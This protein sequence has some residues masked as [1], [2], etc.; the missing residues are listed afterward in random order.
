[1]RRLIVALTASTTAKALARGSIPAN[2]RMAGSYDSLDRCCFRLLH[3]TC[4]GILEKQELFASK[5][6]SSTELFVSSPD[7]G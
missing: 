1:M 3:L 5:D 6:Y 7:K 2:M 4:S